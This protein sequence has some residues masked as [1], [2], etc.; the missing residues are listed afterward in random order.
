MHYQQQLYMVMGWAHRCS[1]V[2]WPV[3]DWLGPRLAVTCWHCGALAAGARLVVP[4]ED[5]VDAVTANDT[6]GSARPAISLDVGSTIVTAWAWG[7]VLAKLCLQFLLKEEIPGGYRHTLLPAYWNAAISCGD[8]S[9]PW[10]LVIS[11]GFGSSLY[12]WAHWVP[13]NLLLPWVCASSCFRL[14]QNFVT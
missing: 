12:I 10:W 3:P 14:L 1:E 11:R 13:S 9:S 6:A 7:L 8:R 4:T 5:E 2:H